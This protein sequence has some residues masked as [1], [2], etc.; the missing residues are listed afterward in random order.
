MNNTMG[1]DCRLLI[2][3]MLHI[4]YGILLWDVLRI[5]LQFLAME[6]FYGDIC[7]EMFLLQKRNKSF[8]TSREEEVISW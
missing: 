7:Y 8:E 5:I 2:W 1:H 4:H 3:I 6:P